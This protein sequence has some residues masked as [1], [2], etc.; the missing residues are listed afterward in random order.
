MEHPDNP[1]SSPETIGLTGAEL[2][3]LAE[4]GDAERAALE[5]ADELED[6]DPDAE[7]L[8]DAERA[9]LEAEPVVG[10]GAFENLE[11]PARP[12]SKAERAKRRAAEQ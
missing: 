9:E 8:A 12:L 4:L 1:A 6:E 3:E 11:E 7:L 10:L 5:D 2:E